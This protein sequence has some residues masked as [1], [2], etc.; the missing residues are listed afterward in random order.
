[1]ED[2]LKEIRIL[3]GQH[4]IVVGCISPNNNTFV[5]LYPIARISCKALHAFS[6]LESDWKKINCNINDILIEQVF[7]FVVS[8]N[9]F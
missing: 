2:T 6:S 5:E 4:H 3:H 7:T 8:F 1:M 9:K